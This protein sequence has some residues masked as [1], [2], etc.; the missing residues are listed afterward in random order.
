MTAATLERKG[1][2]LYVRGELDFDSVAALLDA[3]EP[4]FATDPPTHIDL[5]GVIRAN[6]AGIALLVEWLIQARRHGQEL[7]FINVP[8]QMRAIIA[9][10]DLDAILP[11]A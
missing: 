11:L 8:A 2:T 1:Q 3:T 5:S 7:T 4:P 10:A 9:I 6:S